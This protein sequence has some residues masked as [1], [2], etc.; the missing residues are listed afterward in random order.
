[1]P[2]DTRHRQTT[3]QG[4]G[5]GGEAGAEDLLCNCRFSQ[6]APDWLRMLLLCVVVVLA[7]DKCN[8]NPK[9]TRIIPIVSYHGHTQGGG[10]GRR[11]V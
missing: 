2:T 4:V 5:P 9:A 8:K 3:A 10:G 7:G 11:R 6:A 1:M